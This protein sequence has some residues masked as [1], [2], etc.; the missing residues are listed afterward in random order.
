MDEFITFITNVDL[1]E[2]GTRLFMQT[3]DQQT[4]DLLLKLRDENVIGNTIE[5]LIVQP[6]Y[7]PK[8]KKFLTKFFNCILLIM[9][10]KIFYSKNKE[11]DMSLATK[12]FGFFNEY[13][14]LVEFSD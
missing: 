14:T 3:T 7:T 8:L 6:E 13:V 9:R 5:L 1:K 10:K 4:D 2:F 11:I 12:C